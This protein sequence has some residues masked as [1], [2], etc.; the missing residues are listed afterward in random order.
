MCCWVS[1]VREVVWTSRKLPRSRAQIIA[2]YNLRFSVYF[3]VSARQ[4]AGKPHKSDLHIS[5]NRASD[6][7]HLVSERVTIFNLVRQSE[8]VSL[9]CDMVEVATESSF[10]FAV[11]TKKKG[12]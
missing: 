9:L 3:V 2:I 7:G 6:H 10:C 12:I 4:A 8:R 11:D 5:L 1:I